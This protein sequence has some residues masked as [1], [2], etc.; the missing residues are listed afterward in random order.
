MKRVKKIFFIGAALALAGCGGPKIVPDDELAQIFH[1]IYLV[2][3]YVAQRNVRIDTLNIYE[4]VFKAYG[5]TSEDI[6]YTIGNFAKRKSA[7]LSDDVVELAVE[8]LRRESHHYHRRIAVRDT[9]A[10]IARERYADTVRYADLEALEEALDTLP[11]NN[12]TRSNRDSLWVIHYLPNAE[13]VA[14]LARSWGD[15]QL[16]DTLIKRD[17]TNFRPPFVDSLGAGVR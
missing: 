13:A 2:N 15:W 12:L 3:G 1:D 6:Q 9:I 7:R 4:P 5:Y 8:M 10:R 11:R 14:R 16:L 17:E